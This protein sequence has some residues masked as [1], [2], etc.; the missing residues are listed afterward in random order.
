LASVWRAPV[1]DF[2]D[3]H[4]FGSSRAAQEILIHADEVFS[5]DRQTND[6]WVVMPQR[7][8]ADPGLVTD[9][10]SVL[11]GMRT[12]FFQDVVPESG[13]PSLGFA[14]PQRQYKLVSRPVSTASSNSAIVELQFGSRQTNGV[15]AR[16]TDEYSIYTV[17]TNDF[18]R[19]P[20]AS[21]QLRD[22]RLWACDEDDLN[23]AIVKKDGKTIQITRKEK[24]KWVIAPGSQG[25]IKNELALEE[26]MRGL[27]HVS[28]L[29]WIARTGQ[30][31]ERFGLKDGS[32]QI[33]LDLKSGT[34]PTIVFGGEASPLS[35]YGMTR[36]DNEPIVFEFPWL[37]FRDLMTWLPVQ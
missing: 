37:L 27:T 6:T 29:S 26:T 4:L 35:V 22:R 14:P 17:S 21:W 32:L 33:T 30:H 5:V 15:L 16:R 9:M 10:L 36:V 28:A 8:Q 2:R 24:Y 18:D 31:L 25:M 7:F 34:K 13:L 23:G 11:S 1:N 3:Q 20:G 19:L 12:E